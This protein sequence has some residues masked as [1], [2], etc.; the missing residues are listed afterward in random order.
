MLRERAVPLLPANRVRLLMPRDTA[1]AEA[2]MMITAMTVVIRTGVTRLK[3]VTGATLIE[4]IK[5]TGTLTVRE[6][7][8]RGPTGVALT[9][10]ETV[11]EVPIG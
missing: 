5:S 7:A 3:T 10:S 4:A 11:R 6:I 1:K 9:G 8:R 2:M